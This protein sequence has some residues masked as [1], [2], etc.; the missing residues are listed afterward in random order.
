MY[1]ESLPAMSAM[2]FVFEKSGYYPFWMKNTLIPLDIVWINEEKEVLG[3]KTAQPCISDPCEIFQIEAPV[4][5]VLEVN[6][7]EFEGKIGA[8]IQFE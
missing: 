3:V 4:R 1:R 7:G 6:A 8:I 5:W 2:L